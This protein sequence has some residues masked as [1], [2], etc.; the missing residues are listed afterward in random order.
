MSTT[1]ERCYDIEGGTLK[2]VL[3]MDHRPSERQ[4]EALDEVADSYMSCFEKVHRELMA[5]DDDDRALW[6]LGGVENICA[7]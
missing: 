3:K 7:G 4:Y 6:E 5:G 2:V 1:T